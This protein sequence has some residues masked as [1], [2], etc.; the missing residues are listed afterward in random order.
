[1]RL[2]EDYTCATVATGSGFVPT[3]WRTPGYVGD[4]FLYMFYGLC[5]AA[6]QATVYWYES[7]VLPSAIS[8]SY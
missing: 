1:M 4:M 2:G 8:S 6:W 5:D 7:L 3:D